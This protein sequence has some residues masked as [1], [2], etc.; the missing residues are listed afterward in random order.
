MGFSKDYKSKWNFEKEPLA[1]CMASL[2]FPS[3]ISELVS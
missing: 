1:G 2:C 3:Q